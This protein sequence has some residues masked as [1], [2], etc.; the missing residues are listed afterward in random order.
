MIVGKCDET[1]LMDIYEFLCRMLETE[2]PHVSE[3]PSDSSVVAPKITK[4]K[5]ERKKMITI[6]NPSVEAI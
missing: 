1:E 5:K 2:Y 4:C 3:E 6:T